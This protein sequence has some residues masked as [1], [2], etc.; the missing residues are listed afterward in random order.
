MAYV[1]SPVRHA[2]EVRRQIQWIAMNPRRIVPL[3]VGEKDD[4]VGM[5]LAK[6]HRKLLLKSCILSLADANP[7]RFDDQHMTLGRDKRRYIPG[8]ER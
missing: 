1:R 6:E 7:V 8:I 4:D 3:L 2:V 5:V